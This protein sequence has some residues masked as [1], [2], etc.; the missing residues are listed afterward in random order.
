MEEVA[1]GFVLENSFENHAVKVTR[2]ADIVGMIKEAQAK[3]CRL[4]IEAL[5]LKEMLEAVDKLVKTMRWKIVRYHRWCR[6]T[7][8]VYRIRCRFSPGGLLLLCRF[9]D[10]PCLLFLYGP[11][12]YDI[13]VQRKWPGK[14][15]R[16]GMA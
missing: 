12:L 6:M 14:P 10:S 16:L 4:G 11:G 1:K 8:F 15:V 13:C 3:F 7:W 2:S 5:E 9:H